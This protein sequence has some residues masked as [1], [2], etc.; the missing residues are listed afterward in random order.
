MRSLYC[1][2]HAIVKG[3]SITCNVGKALAGKNSRTL[4]IRKL[5][6][7]DPLELHVCQA[8]FYFDSI[9]EPVPDGERGWIT[10]VRG[11]S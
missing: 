9:G 3:D 1:C 4:H 11:K 5:M 7:G 8:C 2:G 6:R 10:E